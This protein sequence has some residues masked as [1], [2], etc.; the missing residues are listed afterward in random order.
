M[1]DAARR[2]RRDR[3][4][5]EILDLPPA[6]RTAFLEVECADDA[7]LREE[8]ERLAAREQALSGGFLEPSPAPPEHPAPIVLTT[9]SR[10][11][12][13]EIRHEIGH[14]GMGIVYRA[15]DPLARRDVALKL[16][17]IERPEARERFLR[18]LR[19]MASLRH[20]NVLEIY[21]V[22]WHEQ[23]PYFV[24]TLLHGQDL[25]RAIRG[26]GC[27]DEARKRDIGQQLARAL[28]AVHAAGV[29]HR[30]LKPG[31]VFLES[32]GGVKLLDFGI[33]RGSDAKTLTN[34]DA[35]CGTPAYAA[36]EQLQFERATSASDIYSYGLVIAELFTGRPIRSGSAAAVM[37]RAL[38][39]PI[40]YAALADGCPPDVLA[41][42]RDVTVSNP[43]DRPTA[44]EIVRRLELVPVV[45]SE[46]PLSLAAP[47][48]LPAAAANKRGRRWWP[49]ATLILGSAA[50][51]GLIY[52][53]QP[54]RDEGVIPTPTPPAPT[55]VS[56]RRLE[57]SLH[58]RERGAVLLHGGPVAMKKDEQFRLLVRSSDGGDL[59]VV[60][61]S[62]GASDLSVLFPSPNANAGS[63]AVPRE[64]PLRI[65]RDSWLRVGPRRGVQRLWV[66]WTR[67]RIAALASVG[68]WA[69]P[70]DL[71]VVGDG[72]E[73]ERLREY[74]RAGVT[75]EAH[76]S[77]LVLEGNAATLVGRLDIVR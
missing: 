5:E 12:R 65:P 25:A 66:L 55:V 54:G 20:P 18:E 77:T 3:L 67:E 58:T 73:R 19:V 8:V 59:Y 10:V 40:D 42:V 17:A 53:T 36:P 4:L 56:V 31:N 57:V 75:Q 43:D 38:N 69:N 46:P 24:S 27:G 61:E 26:D 6:D 64:E 41:L 49:F 70:T 13:Y 28:V 9:G 74:L 45:S 29:I 34:L 14:G 2:D 60:A 44:S 50:L 33:A 71:G 68:R 72:A 32:T 62:V 39:E 47:T 63:T 7:P 35:F 48:P 21:D 11:G 51:V 52:G 15:F 76:G 30:D 16:L 23:T 37:Y 22:G 1:N